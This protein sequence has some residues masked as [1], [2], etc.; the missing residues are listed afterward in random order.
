MTLNLNEVWRIVERIEKFVYRHWKLNQK[1]ESFIAYLCNLTF[2]VCLWWRVLKEN[3]ADGRRAAT[4]T[5]VT[6]SSCYISLSHL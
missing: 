1:K 4:L 5:C 2:F 6:V 3:M